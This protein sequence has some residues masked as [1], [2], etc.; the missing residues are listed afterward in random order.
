MIVIGG[1]GGGTISDAGSVVEVEPVGAEVVAGTVVEVVVEVVVV[2]AEV[3][4]VGPTEVVG[5]V[6]VVVGATGLAP[7]LEE[8]A[9]VPAALTAETRK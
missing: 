8:A 2:G 7:A 5:A 4:V 3:V 9:P 1:N 6:V